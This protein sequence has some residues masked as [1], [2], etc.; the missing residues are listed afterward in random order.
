MSVSNLDIILNF[1]KKGGGAQTATKDLKELDKATEGAEKKTRNF[2]LAQLGLAAGIT[3]G[4]VSILKQI[5]A[6]TQ[7]GF[8]YGNMETALEAYAG[9]AERA[10]ALTD[11]VTEASG[12]SLSKMEAMSSA[13][14]L[15][16][17]GL[18]STAKEA[19]EV[20]RT[21]ITLGATMGK[22]AQGAFE[23]F[24]LLLANQS[25]LRL[26]TYGISAGKVR[27]RMAELAAEFPEMDRTMRFNN[28]T[29]EIA[30][31][32]MDQLDEAGFQATSSLDRWRA[33][34]EDAKLAVS[35]WLAEGL[36]PIT[37]GLFGVRDAVRDQ[38][39]QIL[40]SSRTWEEY[41]ERMKEVKKTAGLLAFGIGE[42]SEGQF[43]MARS[44]MTASK[45]MQDLGRTEE[46]VALTLGGLNELISENETLHRSVSSAIRGPL[47][48]A[49]ERWRTSL[50]DV[51]EAH[52]DTEAD[53]QGLIEKSQDLRTSLEETTSQLIFQQSAAGLDADATLALARALGIMDEA[54][55]AVAQEAQRLRTAY[56]LGAISADEFAEQTRILK[57][58][59]DSLTSRGIEVTADTLEAERN[60]DAFTAKLNALPDTTKVAIVTLFGDLG[61]LKR[62]LDEG[63]FLQEGAQFKIPDKGP[64]GDRVPVNFVA[65][66]GETVTVTPRDGSPPPSRGGSNHFNLNVSNSVDV[67]MLVALIEG[68]L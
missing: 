68:V 34:V 47:G 12:R 27:E 54:T 29:L 35:K 59:V 60:V 13:T 62:D 53:M 40:A 33:T 30:R 56:D 16:S 22:D 11:A 45:H 6:M 25:I 66:R 58:D 61:T 4:A 50:I 63:G 39:K 5:P 67:S 41:V 10:R 49:I 38:E 14:R 23:E 3:A 52:G 20:T 18:A 1:I 44:A 55:F 17:L 15:L 42:I 31:E 36:L 46:E 28:A 8:Q 2:S 24:T 32:K 51:G 57:Q 64:L 21:A 19:E 37:D 43:E 26:D 65:E 48:K 7:L 9:G